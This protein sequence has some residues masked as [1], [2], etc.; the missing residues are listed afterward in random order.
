MLDFLIILVDHL[1][2]VDGR[3]GSQNKVEKE[4]LRRRYLLKE[5]GHDVRVSIT[6]EDRNAIY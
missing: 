5:E 3:K 1:K 4:L 6:D 2:T